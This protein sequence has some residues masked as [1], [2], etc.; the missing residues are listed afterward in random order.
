MGFDDIPDKIQRME[1][2]VNTASLLTLDESVTK[3][4]IL[5]RRQHKKLKLGDAIIAATALVYDLILLTR[6]TSDFKNILGL[7]CVNP[8]DL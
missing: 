7:K 8:H 3:Q 5:L 1:E 4:T 2:F 6:N